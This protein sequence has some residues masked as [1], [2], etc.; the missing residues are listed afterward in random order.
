MQLEE[1]RRL[2]APWPSEQA[3]ERFI[4]FLELELSLMECASGGEVDPVVLGEFTSLLEESFPRTWAYIE[5]KLGGDMSIE[6]FNELSTFAWAEARAQGDVGG[7]TLVVGTWAE[8][9]IARDINECFEVA[10][11]RRGL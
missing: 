7:Q 2:S 9:E 5:K 4:K 11:K 8:S 1:V 10:K 6:I 3:R